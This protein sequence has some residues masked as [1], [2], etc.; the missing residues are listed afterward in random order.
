MTLSLLLRTVS[1]PLAMTV[2]YPSSAISG[3]VAIDILT[4]LTL[5][6]YD[7]SSSSLSSSA[8]V[9][10]GPRNRLPSDGR[11][12]D[13]VEGGGRIEWVAVERVLGG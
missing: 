1:I 12:V 4:D 11:V 2:S 10:S 13:P 6:T 5:D 9:D 3:L 8:G 7:T